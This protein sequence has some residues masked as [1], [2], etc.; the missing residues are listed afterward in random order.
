MH[1]FNKEAIKDQRNLNIDN[2]THL[3]STNKSNNNIYELI[4]NKITTPEFGKNSKLVTDLHPHNIENPTSFN[5]TSNHSSI[6]VNNHPYNNMQIPNQQ[7]GLNINPLYPQKIA[8]IHQG[9]QMRPNIPHHLGLADPY[10]K[11]NANLPF[12]MNPPGSNLVL[13][14]PIQDY[15]KQI[16]LIPNPNTGINLAKPSDPSKIQHPQFSNNAQNIPPTKIDRAMIPPQKHFP[17]EQSIPQNYIEIQNKQNQ[18]NAPFKNPPINN[19]RNQ[20][21]QIRPAFQIPNQ[22]GAQQHPVNPNN[23]T[24]VPRIPQNIGINYPNKK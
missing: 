3:N 17:V 11:P 23:F 18:V 6:D 8:Q 14:P 10:S 22:I 9:V 24:N 21:P 1:N 16:P 20:G 19:I 15:S 7:I 13:R 2:Q 12:N 4:S 5:K